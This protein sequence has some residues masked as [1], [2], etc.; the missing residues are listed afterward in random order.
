MGERRVKRVKI[1]VLVVAV[2]FSFL[3]IYFS[4]ELSPKKFLQI[5]FL[6]VGQ[7]DSI[8]LQ[9]PLGG[10]VLIDGGRDKKV[11]PELGK[12]LPSISNSIELVIATHDDSDHITGLIDVLKRYKVKVLLYSLPN[13][14][15]ELSRELLK[16]ARE[17]NVRVVHVTKPMIIKSEDGVIIKI[18]F[19]VKNMD[20]VSNSEVLGNDASIVTQ[21]IFG[22]NKILLTGDLPQTGEKF[23]INK[24]GENLKSNILKLGHHGSDS[25]TNPEFLQIVKPEVAIVSAGKDNTFGHP[26][27]SVMQL[28]EKFGIKVLRTDELGTIHIYSNGL[29][30]W[31][32]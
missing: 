4:F 29:N 14:S 11:L 26:H 16:V 13:S 17:K 5:S 31:Q 3:V 18:L 25:S 24:Y 22:E 23:L 15:S 12:N 2:F 7:G 27:R 21:I 9:T 6:D 19:P 1:S 32:E 10:K 30:F 8:L 20:Q 28:M